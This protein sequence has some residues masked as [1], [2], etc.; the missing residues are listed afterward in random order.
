[1]LVSAVKALGAESPALKDPSKG[2]LPDVEDVREVSIKIAMAVIKKA[3][4]EGLAQEVQ[5][6][7]EDEQLELWV[8]AQMWEPRYRD[9][10]RVGS[11]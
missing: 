8:K 5:I 2:L 7:Q 6:P 4:E 9:L 3:G 1:M 11:N 10:V